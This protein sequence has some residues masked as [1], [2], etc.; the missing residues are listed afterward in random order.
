MI[1]YFLSFKNVKLFILYQKYVECIHL[2]FVFDYIEANIG[3]KI[4]SKFL[5]KE[6]YG[7]THTKNI[8]IFFLL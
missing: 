4:A 2:S 7:T 5:S 6:N 3:T 1:G 8:K